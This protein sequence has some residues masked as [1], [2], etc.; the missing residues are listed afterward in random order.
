MHTS[1]HGF[2][3]LSCAQ[4]SAFDGWFASVTSTLIA[5]HE[6]VVKS[7]G[8]GF[9]AS[10]ELRSLRT[11]YPGEIDKFLSVEKI[12][13]ENRVEIGWPGQRGSVSM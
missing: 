4:H 3:L 1:L 10:Q 2:D 12:V 8:I 13:L 5:D 7:H 6:T 11:T 9:V